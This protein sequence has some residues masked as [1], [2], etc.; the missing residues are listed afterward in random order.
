MAELT[1]NIDPFVATYMTHIKGCV[2]IPTY[3]FSHPSRAEGIGRT[4]FCAMI[5]PMDPTVFV[6]REFSMPC[7]KNHFPT[8]L[9]DQLLCY[10][11]SVCKIQHVGYF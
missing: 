10:L 7:K 11:S 6:G 1:P 3:L 5:I 4:N 2:L 9:N 8:V